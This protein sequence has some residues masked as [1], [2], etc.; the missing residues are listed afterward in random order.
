MFI[1]DYG[2]CDNKKKARR[3]GPNDNEHGWSARRHDPPFAQALL[4]G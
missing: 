3:G 1:I 4:G 2:L